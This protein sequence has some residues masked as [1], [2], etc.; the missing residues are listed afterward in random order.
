MGQ[1]P[2][3][4]LNG[5]HCLLLLCLVVLSVPWYW[6]DGTIEPFVLGMPSWAAASFGVCFLF[7]ITTAFL[8]LT[9]WKDDDEC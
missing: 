6:P 8:I 1:K 2:T 4:F 7:A 3:N 5:F 9:R